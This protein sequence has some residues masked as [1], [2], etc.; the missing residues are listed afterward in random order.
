LRAEVARFQAS[1]KPRHLT[2][3]TFYKSETARYTRPLS[4]IERGLFSAGLLFGCSLMSSLD[5][6]MFNRTLLNEN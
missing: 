4:E 1:Y 6:A 3:H 2:G 5:S